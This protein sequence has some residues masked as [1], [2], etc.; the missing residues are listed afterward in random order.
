M[1]LRPIHTSKL[2][3]E[4]LLTDNFLEPKRLEEELVIIS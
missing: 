3:V 1:R 2:I 4:F